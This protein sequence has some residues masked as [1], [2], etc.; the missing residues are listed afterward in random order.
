M[1][2]ATDEVIDPPCRP[3]GGDVEILFPGPALI[4]GMS[5]VLRGQGQTIG[6]EIFHQGLD[7]LQA[8]DCA[9]SAD[10][11]FAQAFA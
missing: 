2:G 4:A 3:G 7:E 11:G 5:L 9:E 10:L 1:P 6:L 8:V